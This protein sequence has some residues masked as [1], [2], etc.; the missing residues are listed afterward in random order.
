MLKLV[1]ANAANAIAQAQTAVKEAELALGD[2][3]VKSPIAGEVIEI[4]AKPGE[5]IGGDGVCEVAD[6]NKMYVEAEVYV[7]DISRVAIGDIAE[8]S[9]EALPNEVLK[10]KVIEISRYV[11]TNRLFSQDPSEYTDMKV[12]NVKISLDDSSKVGKLLGSQV[13][14]RIYVQK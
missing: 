14:V 3:T 6:T 7:S 5:A 8:C 11:K 1:E 2:F 9:P 10:G 13:R 12:I 4:H